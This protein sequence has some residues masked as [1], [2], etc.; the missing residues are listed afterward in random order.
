MFLN[1]AIYDYI[2]KNLG[3]K[4]SKAGLT[5]VKENK[6]V[7]VFHNSEQRYIEVVIHD[8]SNYSVIIKYE[9]AFKI[10][11]IS[12][13]NGRDEP[14]YISAALQYLITKS[15][16]DLFIKRNVV[17]DSFIDKN[18]LG[19]LVGSNI[20]ESLR[21]PL[22]PP[23][24]NRNLPEGYLENFKNFLLL[25][26]T[27][28]SELIR[29]ISNK[30]TILPD[31]VVQ[32]HML[33]NSVYDKVK[34]VIIKYDTLNQTIQCSECDAPRQTL[35]PHQYFLFNSLIE[36][37]LFQRL[38]NIKFEDIKSDFLN[39]KAL[40]TV[41]F[42][43]LYEIGIVN[44][45]IKVTNKIKS[46][47][48][49]DG[50]FKIT[51]L[52]KEFTTNNHR[53]L[54][55][56]LTQE[57]GKGVS[58]NLKNIFVWPNPTLNESETPLLLETKVSGN[59]NKVTG[60]TVAVPFPSHFSNEEKDF[61]NKISNSNLRF[62][63]A[64]LLKYRSLLALLQANF[65]TLNGIY[66]YYSSSI[67][68]NK[69][70]LFAFQ[71]YPGLI[72]VGFQVSENDSFYT[73]S[74]QVFVDDV[75][76]SSSFT[77][78]EAFIL[79]NNLA[80]LYKD[81]HQYYA[82]IVDD[83]QEMTIQKEEKT[84]LDRLI[85][86]LMQT[87]DVDLPS[88]FE[89]DV[90][91]CHNGIRE[92]NITEA[93]D[94]LIFTPFIRYDDSLKFNVIEDNYVSYLG[95]ERDTYFQIDED[96]KVWFINFFTNINPA[97]EES[98]AL[99]KNFLI[100]VKDFVKETWFLEF[101]ELCKIQEINVFGQDNLSNFRFSTNQAYIST[102]ISSGIDWFDVDVQIKFGDLTV[103]TK[104]W[105][106]AVRNNEKFVRLDDGTFGI[107]PDEWLNK[108]KKLAI[109]VD[110]DK[111]VLTISKYKFGVVD[112]LFEEL[113]DDKL[114]L[115]IQNKI[116]KLKNYKGASQYEVPVTIQ[117]TLRPY[118]IEGYQWLKALDDTDFGGCLA[119]DM[120]LGKTLE[121]ICLLANQKDLKRG[122][123]VV[124]APR[125][126]LFNW[127]AEID[128]F[129]P[130]LT[131]IL[132]HGNDRSQ[133]RKQL[134]NYDIVITT[135]DTTSIDIEFLKDLKFNYAI[136]DESQAVKNPNSKRYKA[137][138][139]L[140]TRNK[141]VMT[142]TPMENNTFDLY[143]QFSF[144]NPGILGSMT[145]FKD[146]FSIPID[147]HN[148]VEAINLLKKIIS[149]FFL[150]RTKEVV[151]KD[152]PE[153][154]ENVI[155]CEM[156]PTQRQMYDQLKAQIKQD[157]EGTLKLQG[158]NKS[159]FKILEA[160]LR[161]R[162]MCNAPAL[163]DKTLPDHKKTSVKVNTLVEIIKNDLAG[164]NA[165]VFSQ[166]TSMLD[167]IRKELD[168]EGIKY[169]YLDGA[170][171]DRKQAV[172]D[173]QDDAET[174]VFLISLKAGN[175]GLNL[176]KADYVYIVDPWWNPAVEAQ[177]IDRTHRIGQDKHIFAYKMI[178]KDTIEEKIMLLQQKKKKITQDL[179]SSDE[180]VFKSLSKEELIDLF[181]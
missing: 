157:V 31:G 93:G 44:N 173:F 15:D 98:Y 17:S 45:E 119:D 63:N 1:S 73:V 161:L 36:G 168:K 21:M 181:T 51:T 48:D 165:L 166:F 57:K 4:E 117:A 23:I 13:L 80:Y 52:L 84:E 38:N 121:M 22:Q 169:A 8:K 172:A 20:D 3:F 96:E 100:S 171:R 90:I 47:Q 164:H 50:I 59:S 123:S 39:G 94:F 53:L 109:S 6:I 159:K 129:C 147:R 18:S 114:F 122:T 85:I 130:S 40:S 2:G 74:R 70:T 102:S 112:E 115:D 9:N 177:A 110:V 101:F 78:Y 153:K 66:N 149:P 27:N 113:S 68:Y 67:Y 174:K 56:T 91:Q 81:V 88:D 99:N 26:K 79:I 5:L 163:L 10:N 25:N 104:A 151:A 145:S 42:N 144:V 87:H 160:L 11:S 34:E 92:V 24:E 120:G 41:D 111:E 62:K 105:M 37:N 178:C 158:L 75:E 82:L 136:L 55:N 76:I 19:N 106:D 83:L 107:I 61:Y 179:I 154:S 170:T 141:M 33:V 134:L 143:A 89:L 125:S 77:I 162:Q 12:M 128:K 138:R 167:I 16:Q 135:Y 124:V 95:E 155:Y 150:R 29:D 97:F 14:V 116:F 140:N 64:N 35:C 131:Y 176:I 58:E 139:L 86:S 156:E 71:F 175:T 142:G 148:D 60:A 180:N 46:F 32:S 137:V 108:L 65:D 54:Q 126:L 103:S 49:K 127:A 146:R 118:Q 7:D 152:L 30:I 72:R 28:F 43:K 132:Y 133:L 69:N